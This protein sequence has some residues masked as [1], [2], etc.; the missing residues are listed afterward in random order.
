[1]SVTTTGVPALIT[2]W[3]TRRRVR[4]AAGVA[5]PKTSRSGRSVSA[6]A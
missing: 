1:M 6:T 4:S 2:S 5:T 3:Y